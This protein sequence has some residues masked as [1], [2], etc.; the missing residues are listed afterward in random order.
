[1]QKLKN[2]QK[3]KHHGPNVQL[4]SSLQEK[5]RTFALYLCI[6]Y[7]IYKLCPNDRDQ[8]S[9]YHS[10]V[11]QIWE[12]ENLFALIPRVYINWSIPLRIA[13]LFLFSLWKDLDILSFFLILLLEG[14]NFSGLAFTKY[15]YENYI[16]KIK[17]L[18]QA[19]NALYFLH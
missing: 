6:M 8:Y 3:L 15:Y 11:T 9:M 13:W 16:A 10:L 17:D 7:I 1:M 18:F 4:Y 14:H 12:I 5:K 19:L 2:N